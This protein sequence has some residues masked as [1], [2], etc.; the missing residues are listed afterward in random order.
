VL[1]I[2]VGAVAQLLGSRLRH[3]DHPAGVLDLPAAEVMPASVVP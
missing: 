2:E 3:R 1:R